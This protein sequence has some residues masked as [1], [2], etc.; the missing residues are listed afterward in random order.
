M[1]AARRATIIDTF[2]VEQGFRNLMNACDIRQ[3]G[4][5]R[6]VADG[7]GSMNDLVNQYE[8]DID[9]F[10]SYLIWQHSTQCPN[11]LLTTSDVSIHWGV[12]LLLC[13]LLQLTSHP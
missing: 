3:I 6:L 13:L 12:I 10:I 1:A 2:N 7:F 4:A 5:N 11:L 8:F 9:D